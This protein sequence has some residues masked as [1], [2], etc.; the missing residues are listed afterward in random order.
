MATIRARLPNVRTPTKN[1]VSTRISVD[2][3]L[4]GVPTSQSDNYVR[5]PSLGIDTVRR[6]IDTNARAFINRRFAVAKDDIDSCLRSFSS[7][8]QDLLDGQMVALLPVC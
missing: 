7:L 2:T 4:F 1:G 6:S 8:G 5:F 3:P